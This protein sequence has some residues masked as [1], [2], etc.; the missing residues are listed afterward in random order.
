MI[1]V[2]ERI[3]EQEVSQK[4]QELFELAAKG[5]AVNKQA[6]EEK[7]NTFADFEEI[8][9]MSLESKKEKVLRIVGNPME[10]RQNAYDPK[11]VL[12]TKVVK[13]DRKGYYKIK[14]K[15]ILKNGYY[16]PDPECILT[17]FLDMVYE[18]KWFKYEDKDVD[19]VSIVKQADGTIINT[20]S[21]SRN[22]TGYYKHFRENTNIYKIL[23]AGNMKDK[24]LFP[25]EVNN[26]P[27]KKVVMNVIDRHDSWCADNKHTKLLTSKLNPYDVKNDDG[28]TYTIKFV[29]TGVPIGLYDMMFD[30]LKSNGS[31]DMDLVVTKDNDL[32]AKYKVHDI[33]DTAP[34]Y[35]TEVSKSLGNSNPL[36]EDYEKYDLDK[37]YYPS[38]YAMISKAFAHLFKLAD[39]EL[40]TNFSI[41]LVQ[42]VEQEKQ[43]REKNQ[44]GEE[45]LLNDSVVESTLEAPKETI[46]EAPRRESRENSQESS[47]KT[48]T[49]ADQCSK[50]LLHWK[51]LSETDKQNYIDAL[52]HFVEGIPV[53]K[54]N[55]VPGCSNQACFIGEYITAVPRNV[56]QCPQ[57]GRMFV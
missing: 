45:K 41:E 10:V 35:I 6:Q 34:K 16:V 4:A 23:T 14:R 36:T 3:T 44:E 38:S 51:D 50:F 22:K 42:L 21:K 43:E 20:A 30:Q 53:F 52:S 15:H 32:L 49:L 8:E 1:E 9:Y 31:L 48:L 39:V 12:E 17:R 47:I 46:T 5:R 57:C 55:D 7:T 11:L 2:A 13:P 24:E 54:S 33:T 29:D 19:N 25:V 56:N 26:N 18:G 27:P 28:S 40:N 37:L